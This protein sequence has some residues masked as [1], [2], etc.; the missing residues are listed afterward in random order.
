MERAVGIIAEQLAVVRSRIES[1]R[2]LQARY[3]RRLE[4]LQGRIASIDG[5]LVAPL[6]AARELV[7]TK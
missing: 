5:E 3:E 4:R 6:P 1:M 7:G 2:E